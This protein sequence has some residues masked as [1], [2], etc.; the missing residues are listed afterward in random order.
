MSNI[1]EGTNQSQKQQKSIPIKQSSGER[2]GSEDRTGVMIVTSTLSL[3]NITD[4]QRNSKTARKGAKIL[5]AHFFL[6]LKETDMGST[7][8]E[9]RTILSQSS[10]V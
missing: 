9:L 8:H 1:D 4:S 6:N 10:S 2:S 3:W 7:K 5:L